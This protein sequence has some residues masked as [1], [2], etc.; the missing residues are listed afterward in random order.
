MEEFLKVH[1]VL[2]ISFR[3]NSVIDSD[4]KL[5]IED[6]QIVK[7]D[8]SHVFFAKA[9]GL[10]QADDNENGQFVDGRSVKE[11]AFRAFPF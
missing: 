9:A 7:F 6:G 10:F 1:A 11:A 2:T 3:L 5:V 4:R 8:H